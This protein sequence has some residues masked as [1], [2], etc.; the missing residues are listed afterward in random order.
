[1][2]R[3]LAD[4]G[5][6]VLLISSEMP[7]VLGMADRL[8]VMRDGRHRRR[9]RRRDVPRPRRCSRIAAGLA[10]SATQAR[11]G[12]IDRG[13]ARRR[14]EPGA[15]C[16]ASA[17]PTCSSPRRSCCW[18]IVASLVSDA[19]LTQRN[20]VNV[21][22]QMVTNGFLSL[23]MLMV[24]RTGGIDLSVGSV[25]ALAGLLATGLQAQMH[26]SAGDR[27]SRWPWARRSAGST[28]G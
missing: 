20:I 1:M 11:S 2:I 18:S 27:W 4:S 23:G 10:A 15:Y 5:A 6:A 7:E 22:R 3:D 9:A 16:S 25:L 12:C 13:R 8:L 26:F 24:I 21:S 14:H 19:F 17:A 28:A